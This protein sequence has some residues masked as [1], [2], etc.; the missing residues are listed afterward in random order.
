MEF[1][2]TA[3]TLN[4]LQG[5]T[6]LSYVT[7]LQQHGLRC[8]NAVA[9]KQPGTLLLHPGNNYG[10]LLSGVTYES[11]FFYNRSANTIDVWVQ[12]LRVLFCVKRS[13]FFLDDQL[14]FV[15]ALLRQDLTL[16]EAI[17]AA[18]LTHEL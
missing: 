10:S 4:E 8:P 11:F 2:P 18:N 5:I 17:D 9:Q 1:E 7:L 16:R 13:E 12:E 6:F 15:I 3:L 14:D